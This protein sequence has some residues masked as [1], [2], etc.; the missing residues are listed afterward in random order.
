MQAAARADRFPGQ[1]ELQVS[2]MKSFWKIYAV[3][4][5]VAFSVMVVALINSRP[6]PRPRPATWQAA[7]RSSR[8]ERLPAGIPPK[9]KAARPKPTGPQAAPPQ[10]SVAGGVFTN[11]F[12]V[13]LKAKSGAAVIRYTLDG[14]EP[15]EN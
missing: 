1:S 4:M 2:L 6:R 5:I 13:E 15:E 8:P 10:F 11:R 12:T 14:S 7:P 3:L 9:P